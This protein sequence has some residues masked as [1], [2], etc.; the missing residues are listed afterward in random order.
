MRIK[1]HFYNNSF[2]LSLA[3]KQWIETTQKLPSISSCSSTRYGNVYGGGRALSS[4]VQS[5]ETNRFSC[6]EVH[7]N[8]SCS[9]VQ[10]A[11]THASHP[12]CYS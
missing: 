2:V 8:F 9:L 12:L 11:K 3:L 5:S 1:N 4:P 6:Q 7:C 10:R